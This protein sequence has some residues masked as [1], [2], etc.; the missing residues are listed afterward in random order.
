MNSHVK[1]QLSA[2]MDGYAKNPRAVERHLETCAVCRAYLEELKALSSGLRAL[3]EPAVRPEFLTRVMA[4]ARETRQEHRAHW[5]AR[6]AIPMAAAVILMLSVF[7]WNKGPAPQH[8][9]SMVAKNELSSADV[10]LLTDDEET[11]PDQLISTLSRED[12]FASLEQEWESETDI[13]SLVDTLSTEEL[14]TLEKLLRT[15]QKEDAP[16]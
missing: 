13:E 7:M 16:I 9:A 11:T 14:Q 4:Q 5:F 2:Y 15:Y 6:L 1:D 3:P 12:W 8:P 10:A